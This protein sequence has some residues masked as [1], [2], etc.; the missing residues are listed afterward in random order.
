MRIDSVS[1]ET[2]Q[3]NKMKNPVIAKIKV[4]LKKVDL[5]QNKINYQQFFKEK[6]EEPMGLKS[7]VLKEISKTCYKDIKHLSKK[8]I[9]DICEELLES[10]IRYRR[11]FAFEWAG[12]QVG[13]FERSDFPRFERWLT[14]YVDNWGACDSLCMGVTGHLVAKFPEL[15]AKT[16]KWAKSSNLWHRR[17]SAVSLIQPVKQH[18]LLD[19]I[20]KTADILLMDDQNMVQKGYGWML[21][22]AGDYYPDEVFAYVMK[23]KD[24]MPRTALRY[25]IEKYPPHKR[26]EAMGKS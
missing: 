14:D 21:K 5:P 23:H 24:I 16:K 20:F 8:E 1:N 25:A 12:K 17:A 10:D 15:S 22:V 18:L 9:F 26:K 4:E 13:S 6:L 3:S 19:E 7:S 11:F 2:D